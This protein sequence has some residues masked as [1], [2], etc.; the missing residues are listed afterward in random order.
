MFQRGEE[1][2]GLQ[3]VCEG[4]CSVPLRIWLGGYEVDDID[5]REVSPPAFQGVDIS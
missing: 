4:L 2:Y 1:I 3:Y 5:F